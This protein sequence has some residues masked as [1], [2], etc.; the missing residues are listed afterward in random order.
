VALA[1]A[2]FAVNGTVSKAV[3]ADA[4]TSMQVVEARCLFAAVIFAV[5]AAVRDP[6]ALRPGRHDAAVLV[7][8]GVVGVALVQW[9]YL[10]SISR[11]P[12]SIT[13]LIEFTAPLMIALWVRF[14]RHEPVRTRVWTALALILSGLSLVAQVWHGL[15]LD[16]LGL[17]TSFVAAI[18]LAF[19]YLIGEHAVG[20]RDP[21]AVATWGFGS[22]A[23]AWA[24][25]APWWRFPV[26]A[27][28]LPVRLGHAGLGVDVPAWLAL[29]YVVSLGTVAPFGLVF[30]GLGRIGATRVG[31]VGTL[32][33]LLAGIVAWIVLGE[34][35][36]PLQIAGGAV[37]LAGIV[38]AETAR[39]GQPDGGPP[40]RPAVPGPK[41]ATAADRPGSMPAGVK[42][43]DP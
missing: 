9:L 26:A 2:L 39:P 13:L 17:L 12:V 40:T 16:G 22:A 41:P 14:V 33:P 43:S 28:T 30:L 20:R 10:V 6:R 25:L 18:C 23:V 32:E 21:W 5:I 7:I 35:L 24:G 15:T 19:Y 4:F 34:V 37:V 38:L 29:G 11:M 1:A 36:Q 42:R 31:L 3:M 8:F 27:L